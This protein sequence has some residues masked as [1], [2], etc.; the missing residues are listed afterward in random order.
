MLVLS[1]LL[2]FYGNCNLQFQNF[3]KYNLY[4]NII[5]ELLLVCI[6]AEIHFVMWRDVSLCK[7]DGTGDTYVRVLSEL[8]CQYIGFF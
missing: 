2:N 1:M 6:Y 3:M 4:G 8:N 5:S 7:E